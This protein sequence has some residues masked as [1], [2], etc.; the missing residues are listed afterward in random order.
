MVIKKNISDN[1]ENEEMFQKN[2][3]N[4]NKGSR[5]D[6][7]NNKNDN[8][9]INTNDKGEMRKELIINQPLKLFKV[10]MQLVM[11]KLL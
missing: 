1:I 7:N 2:N 11:I 5:N 9:R 6:N 3:G 8:L 4:Y 10:K